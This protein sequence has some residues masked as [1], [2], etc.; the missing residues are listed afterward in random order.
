MVLD[1][2]YQT[3]LIPAV[4]A[5]NTFVLV[6]FVDSGRKDA[7]AKLLEGFRREC[8]LQN[9]NDDGRE[10]E[11]EWYEKGAC[12]QTMYHNGPHA[13]RTGNIN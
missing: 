12:P 7:W 8:G 2:L 11:I 5:S 1:G 6:L 13:R 9:E 10:G 3:R 4:V